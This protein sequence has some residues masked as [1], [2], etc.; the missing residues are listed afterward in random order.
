[1]RLGT[2]RIMQSTGGKKG[3]EKKRKQDTPVSLSQNER[4]RTLK[5]IGHPSALQ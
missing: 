4:N 3:K 2:D 1:M 5:R